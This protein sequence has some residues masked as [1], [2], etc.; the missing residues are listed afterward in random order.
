MDLYNKAKDVVDYCGYIKESEGNN[1]KI[2]IL[3]DKAESVLKQIAILQDGL[4]YHKDMADSY[5]KALVKIY[6]MVEE[7]ADED[8]IQADLIKIKNSIPETAWRR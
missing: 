7:L 2:S 5:A 3:Q 6:D 8:I 1:E 4:E